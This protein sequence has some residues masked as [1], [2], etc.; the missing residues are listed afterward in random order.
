MVALLYYGRD[1]FVT[2]IVSAV[3]ACIL[4]PVVMLVMKLRIPR[5]AS[6]GIVIGL[7]LVA[8]YLLSLMAWMQISRIREDLP[9]L[10]LARPRDHTKVN[11]KLN[12]S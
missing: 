1:F 9:D 6:T 8:V 2:L 4:D 12:R 5:P 10:Q 11:D 7:A 3:F